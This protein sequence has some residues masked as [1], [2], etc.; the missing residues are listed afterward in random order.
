MI[1]GNEWIH[2]PSRDGKRKCEGRAL[3][4]QVIGF[5]INCP[6]GGK[7]PTAENSQDL[8]KS[9]YVEA[10]ANLRDIMIDSDLRH[11][12]VLR[13]W[14]ATNIERDLRS[15]MGAVADVLSRYVP[16]VEP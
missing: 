2:V 10:S 11:A 7:L 1:L 16:I 9:R 14:E 15:V 13:A 12:L 8:A 4:S 3:A 5:F 6:R